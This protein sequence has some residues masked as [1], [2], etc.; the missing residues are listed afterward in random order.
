[1][2]DKIC[3]ICKTTIDT[4][5]EFV[6]VMHMKYDTEILSKGYYHVV[7]YRKRLN[8]DEEVKKEALS[9][10]KGARKMIGMKDEEIVYV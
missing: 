5:R 7:C 4:S 10:I 1:M 2:K 6:K 8:G 9:F 3:N